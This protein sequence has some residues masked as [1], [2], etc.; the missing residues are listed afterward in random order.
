MIA[1]APALSERVHP[2]H[3]RKGVLL[4]DKN[5]KKT[6]TTE[7][8]AMPAILRIL[9][10]DHSPPTTQPSAAVNQNDLPVRFASFRTECLSRAST[11]EVPMLNRQTAQ[12]RDPARPIPMAETAVPTGRQTTLPGTGVSLFTVSEKPSPAALMTLL[13]EATEFPSRHW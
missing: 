1:I 2:V 9:S 8:G 6:L 11:D 12:I 13:V 4:F 7:K 3:G 10:G 5:V